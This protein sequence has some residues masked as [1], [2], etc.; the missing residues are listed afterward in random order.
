MGLDWRVPVSPCLNLC[1]DI[2]VLGLESTR[3]QFL[4][5]LILDLMISL[6][7][8][9]LFKYISAFFSYSATERSGNHT[10]MG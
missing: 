10:D 8:Q 3:D 7:T 2:K 6:V 1:I 9:V 4:K 5:V